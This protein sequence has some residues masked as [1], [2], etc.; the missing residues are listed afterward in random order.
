MKA[1]SVILDAL[2]DMDNTGTLEAEKKMDLYA[3]KD[4]RMTADTHREE[5]GQGHTTAISKRGAASVTGKESSLTMTAGKD[6]HLQAARISSAGDMT[7]AGK[8]QVELGTAVAEKDNRVTWDRSNDRRDSTAMETGSTLTAG[9]NLTVENGK[10]ITDLEEHHRHKEKGLLSSKTTTTYD[11]VKRTDTTGSIV[12]GDTLT[13]TAGKDISLTGSV[14]ASTKE[15]ALSAGRNIS[16]HAAEETDKEI[17]KKQVKKRGLIGS[18]LGFTIGSEKKKDSYDTEETTQRGSTVGSVKGNV[19]ITAGQ[20]ASVSASDIIAGKD[21]LITGRNVDIESKDNTYRGKEE[22]EYKKSGL[23]V[24]LGGALITA[25]D[26]VIR[27]IKNAGQA[28]DGLLG[29]LYAADAG[30]NLHDAVKTYKNIGDVKKGITLDVSIGSRSAKS[31]SRYQGTEAK[32]S[33]IVS[34]GNIRIKS[35]ENIAVKGSQ[36]TGENVTLQAGKDISLTAAENRKTTEGNSRSKGA[37]ITASFGIGGLQNVGISAGKSKGNME[38]EI[39]THTGSAVTAKETLAME[40]GKDLNITGSKAGGKK[41][42]VKTGNN[43]SI[44]SLQDS[45]TYHSR[46]KESGIHL[47]RDITVR[48]DTGKKK[49]DDPYFSIGKKTDTTDSTYISVTKQA[50]IYAGKEGYDIQV[51]GNTHL[52]GAVIDSKAPAE[53]NKLTTGTL[54]WENIDNKA[55]Y[56]TGGHGISYNGK[57]GR[58][59]KNDP[60]DSWTNNRYGKDTITGQR[61]GMNKITE[62]IY[63]SKIPLNERGILNTPIPSVKGKAGTTTTSA[64]SKGTLTITDKENQK[65]DI[66]KLNRNTENSLNKLKEIFDKTKVEERKRLLEE[67]GIVGNRAIHEIA[68][69]NGWKDLSLIHISEPTRH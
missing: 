27:P 58:G 29:K 26:N 7:I 12:E 15:T 20:T 41:V 25:K 38:E 66:E 18:R 40:S 22:H 54:T 13:M 2:K 62:T 11:E 36:I 28:H 14:A 49:M 51:K 31:D 39:M 46:D 3:G 1:S 4:I 34:Q 45:H 63:G 64:V 37:G 50:G 10:E 9:R 21:T 61:N 48:P 30:F 16:I 53:K 6:I 8:R 44:E 5:N 35:D 42:E 68:S 19:T 52:K 59:D 32:E 65:Q 60:L 67:L 69:H 47:Q 33:R 55:E 57:I 24:S 23:T 43:L 17:H 56:K